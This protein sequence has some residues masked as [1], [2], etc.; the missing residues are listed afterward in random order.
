MKTVLEN[1]G[2]DANVVLDRWLE[3]R[4]GSFVV[5]NER[6]KG[7]VVQGK[8]SCPSPLDDGVD[9]NAVNWVRYL[10]SSWGSGW[11]ARRRSVLA[12][13]TGEVEA[14]QAMAAAVWTH[15]Q[16]DSGE[17]LEQLFGADADRIVLA[18]VWRLRR[19]S[20]L[21]RFSR[22]DETG[23]D[24]ARSEQSVVSDFDE[25]IG[26]NVL[27]EPTNELLW[28]HR[29]G[30][31]TPSPDSDTVFGDIEDAMVGDSHPMGVEAQIGKTPV[32]HPQK[33]AWRQPPTF[34]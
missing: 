12:I 33:A 5:V 11:C 10:R 32:W 24:I 34:C 21:E 15:A 27:Q 3:G 17:K 13:R 18:A 26:K 8:R 22:E 31:L 28:A 9:A 6:S 14:A 19:L 4:E 20:T 23:V 1:L 16:V 25:A 2:D 7:L 30:F 29:G